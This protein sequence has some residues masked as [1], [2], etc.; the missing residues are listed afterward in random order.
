MKFFLWAFSLIILVIFI[1]YGCG[2]G[3]VPATDSDSLQPEGFSGAVI[4]TG[5]WPD[6]V[7]RTHI[8]V[9]RDPLDSVADFNI[10]NLS[11][12]SQEIP[13]GA[14]YYAYTSLD[15]GFVPVGGLIPVGE[16][17][18]V[19]VAQSFSEEVSFSRKDWVVVGVYYSP[20]D[21]SRPGKLI[22][23]KGQVVQ[24]INIKCDFDN[25]PPQPPG[26]N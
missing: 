8:V 22:I 20:D 9:F 6:S 16:Y 14:V 25:P 17:S 1:L 3:I 12:V 2:G 24:D 13:F 10:F 7:K 19:A 15:T 11:F 21:S 23:P 4:F 18:Y 26:G 5:S